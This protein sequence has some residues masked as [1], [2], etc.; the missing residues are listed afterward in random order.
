MNLA[1]KIGFGL[2]VLAIVFPLVGV[3][4]VDFYPQGHVNLA[5]DWN[6]LR[7]I[8]IQTY[9]FNCNSCINPS[10]VADID[11]EDIESDLNT[12]VDIGGDH[13]SGTLYIIGTANATAL[14]VDAGDANFK[15]LYA[16]YLFGDGSKLLNLPTGF[17][18]DTLPKDTTLDSNSTDEA[19]WL[20]KPHTF[21]DDINFSDIGISKSD[22]YPHY[23]RCF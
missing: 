18:A 1:Q 10:D 9:D 6:I 5:W 15:N 21:G 4:A 8:G 20:G 16:D 12:F 7:V 11:K 22:G 14:S 3:A 23:K 2:I 17:G 13:M 19:S